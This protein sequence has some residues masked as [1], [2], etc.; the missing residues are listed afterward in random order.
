VKLDRRFT[1]VHVLGIVREG[2]G[3]VFQVRIQKREYTIT[4]RFF[5]D[6]GVLI[7]EIMFINNS[8]IFSIK[9]GSRTSR[10][11]LARF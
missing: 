10:L 6:F 8:T 1:D 4:V 9:T 2:L 5:N 7:G 11:G 3:Q